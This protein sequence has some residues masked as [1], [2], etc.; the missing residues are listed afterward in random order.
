MEDDTKTLGIYHGKIG[1]YLIVQYAPKN[2]DIP[3]NNNAKTSCILEM[4]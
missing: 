3:Y 1:K 2:A 4:Q